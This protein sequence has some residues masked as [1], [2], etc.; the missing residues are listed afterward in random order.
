MHVLGVWGVV[1]DRGKSE[2]ERESQA[3]SPPSTEAGRGARSH[4]L[5]RNQESD[6]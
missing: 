1:G 3:D 5:S 6:T 2:G 4:H